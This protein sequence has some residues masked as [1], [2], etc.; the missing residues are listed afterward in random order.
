VSTMRVTTLKNESSTIDQIVLNADGSF[1]GELASELGSKL[2]VNAYQPGLELI[3]SQS[4]SAVSSVS[5]NGCFTSA[6]A[7]YRL[8]ITHSISTSGA[9][10]MRLRASGTDNTAS[11]YDVG[12]VTHST[13]TPTSFDIQNQSGWPLSAFSAVLER[14]S[15]MDIY[16]PQTATATQMTGTTGQSSGSILHAVVQSFVHTDASAFDGFSL[17]AGAGTITGTVRVYGYRD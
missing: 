14:W 6:Y 2:D 15:S 13:T 10:N 12:A 8:T 1:G 5:V 16:S 4:F 3:T 7:N 9:T 17:L 11:V